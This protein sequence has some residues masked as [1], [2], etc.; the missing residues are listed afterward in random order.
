M[1]TIRLINL[2]LWKGI[3]HDEQYSVQSNSNRIMKDRILVYLNVGIDIALILA[4]VSY[5]GGG[6]GGEATQL[7]FCY[8]LPLP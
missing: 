5:P 1:I 3:F 7:S 4:F 6:R 8:I 2:Y